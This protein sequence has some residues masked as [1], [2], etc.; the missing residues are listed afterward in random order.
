[1]GYR[2][3]DKPSEWIAISDLM[4]GVMAV[5]MLLLVVSVLQKSYTDLKHK[6]E[7]DRMAQAADPRQQRIGRLMAEL[8]SSLA[9]ATRDGMVALDMDA[10]RITLRDGVFNRGSA[11]VAEQSKE[12]FASIQIMLASFL[13]D[14]PGA[15]IYVEGHTDDRP[16]SRPVT[17]YA[18][19]C[20][21]YDDN[22]TLSAARAREARKLLSLGLDDAASRRVVVAGFGDSQPLPGIPPEDSRQR[23]IEVRLVIPDRGT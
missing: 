15:R 17:D 12:A 11:C 8:E 23:R 20:T 9:E 16:V 3:K 18:R 14:F 4:A 5:V 21:V 7:L 2:M 19:N 22:Y 10:R 13:K 1:M 6:Q